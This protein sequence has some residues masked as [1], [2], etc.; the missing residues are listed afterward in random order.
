VGAERLAAVRARAALGR[1][2][3]WAALAIAGAA[4][5]QPIGS[6]SPPTGIAS[7]CVEAAGNTCVVNVTVVPAADGSCSDNAITVN[8]EFPSFGTIQKIKRVEFRIVTPGYH[9]CAR[10]GDGAFFDN[11]GIPE[12]LFD[13]ESNKKCDKSFVWKRKKADG[14]AYAYLLRFR[15][16]GNQRYCVKDPWVRNG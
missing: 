1:I 14:T 2:V 13:V 16:T 12:D 5:A 9:F 10:A 15:D 7:P 11:V 3:V 8:P 4:G 6:K